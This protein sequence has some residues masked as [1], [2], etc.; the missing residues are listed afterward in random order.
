MN[1]I[2]PKLHTRQDVCK[3]RN[4]GRTAQI[5]DENSGA[6]PAP[7][8]YRG[9]TPLWTTDEVERGLEK[10]MAELVANAETMRARVKEKMQPC[11][12]GRKQKNEA[13]QHQA[14]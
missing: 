5:S 14:A 6:W 4:R 7:T 11:I 10:E 3:L 12:M 8:M 1:A 13:Y 9:R 2:T